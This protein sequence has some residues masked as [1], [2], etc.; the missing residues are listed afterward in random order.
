MMVRYR[1]V[2][3]PYYA[4]RKGAI[5]ALLEKRYVGAATEAW[6]LDFGPK[7]GKWWFRPRDLERVED[8][9]RD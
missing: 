3:S 4:V 7:V 1:V 8:R 5:G 2:K 6:W 9:G